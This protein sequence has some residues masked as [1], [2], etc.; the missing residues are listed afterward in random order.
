MKVKKGLY[1]I[2]IANI[3]NLMIS[4][5][6]GFVLPKFLSIETYSNVKLFQLYITYIGVLSLGFADGMYLKLGGKELSSLNSKEVLDEFKTYKYFQFFVTIICVIIS[7][8]IKNEI[9]LFCSLIILPVNISGYLR[10]LYQAIGKFELYSK[11]TNVNTIL[12]FI[13]NVIILFIIKSNSYY[14]FIF[15]YIIVY[16]IYWYYIENETRKIIKKEKSFFNIMYLIDDIKNGFFLMTGNFCN[17]I[18]IT[19]DR[20]FV[21]NLL[22][23]VKFAYYSF[24]VSIENLLNVFITPISTVMYNYLCNNK[25]EQEVIKIK[26][27]INI[28]ASIIIAGIFPIKYIVITWLDKYTDSLNVLVLL[29]ATQYISIIVRCIHINLYKAEKKQNIYFINML[30]MI[31]ISILLNIVFFMIFKSMEGFAIATLIGNIIWL[32]MGEIYFKSY[33]FNLK[34]YTFTFLTLIIFIA[35]GICSSIIIGSLVYIISTILLSVILMPN[36][37]K[38]IVKDIKYIITK[39]ISTPND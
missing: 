25:D 9:F 10:N 14:I 26:Q 6:T 39:I 31:C 13:I 33:R 4:L 34:E 19:I 37:I 38:L 22:G 2:F 23:I 3:L 11:F 20:L 36:G 32:I 30:I 15:G 5:L 16:Y 29:F 35:L 21:Q 12:L 1:Y 17:V 28:F 18:L 7:L 24:A 27:L 8:I